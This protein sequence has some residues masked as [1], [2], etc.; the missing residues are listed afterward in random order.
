[1]VL[2][3][4]PSSTIFLGCK[5]KTT[6]TTSVFQKNTDSPNG[7][8]N[9]KSKVQSW[10]QTQYQVL[11]W[12]T[13]WPCFVIPNWSKQKQHDLSVGTSKYSKC[14]KNHNLNI[15]KKKKLKDFIW[16]S[17]SCESE[18][19]EQVAFSTST[20]SLQYMLGSANP[21]K[22]MISYCS[23]PWCNIRS[24]DRQETPIKSVSRPS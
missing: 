8:A 13:Y 5:K 20:Y 2:L 22:L 19:S 1:M 7:W 17:P 11:S 14:F 21:L 24:K 3:H 10:A 4:P 18:L 16:S 23:N 15:T 9:R 12:E 6:G